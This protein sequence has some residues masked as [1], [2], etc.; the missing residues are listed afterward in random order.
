MGDIQ[1]P[2]KL[3]G[4]G[5][6]SMHRKQK[7]TMEHNI[8]LEVKPKE[9]TYLLY[10]QLL[11]LVDLEQKQGKQEFLKNGLLKDTKKD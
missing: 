5:H 8:F 10:F 7:K 2:D 9:V 11:N 4:L 1:A 3:P 6:S